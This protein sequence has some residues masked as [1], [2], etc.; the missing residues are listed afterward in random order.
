M[1]LP[2][3]FDLFRAALRPAS[4]EGSCGSLWL[5]LTRK[6]G[7]FW[8]RHAALTGLLSRLQRG[9]GRQTSQQRIV[10]AVVAASDSPEKGILQRENLSTKN[11]TRSSLSWWSGDGLCPPPVAGLP[12]RR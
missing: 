4:T 8:S 11:P 9:P 6:I 5:R 2:S 1:A 7:Q 10:S 12:E 3:E